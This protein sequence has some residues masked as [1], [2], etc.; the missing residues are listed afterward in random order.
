MTSTST[1][2]FWTHHSAG[3]MS[4]ALVVP[5]HAI[6]RDS[7][8]KPAR[9]RVFADAGFPD[10]PPSGESVPES[11]VV[12]L[13]NGVQDNWPDISPDLLDRAGRA[14]AEAVV[15]DRITPRAKVLLENMPWPM[16]AWLVGRSARQNARAFA[17]S[18]LFS[19]QTTGRF[20]LINN[21]FALHVRSAEPN[22]HFHAAFFEHMF[23]R[24]AHRD[25][26]C[27]EVACCAAG[28]EACTFVLSLDGQVPGD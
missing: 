6:L 7:F 22:C 23:Q 1:G 4:A 3:M 13:H 14:A 17:G 21:P 9:D 26:K 19:V 16:A 11:K 27:R 18:G 25:F 28:A 5:L 2:L 20:A 8:G 15:T 12:R 10:A 24:L